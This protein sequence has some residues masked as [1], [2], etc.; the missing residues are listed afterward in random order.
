MAI[1]IICL[2]CQE[3]QRGRTVMQVRQEF[4]TAWAFECPRCGSFRSVTK[5]HI[6]GTL[7]AGTSHGDGTRSAYGKG[8]GNGHRRDRYKPIT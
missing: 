5:D 3:H 8:F 2:S 6:G 7:G 1:T 4:P